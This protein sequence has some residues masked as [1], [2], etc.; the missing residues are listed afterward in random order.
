MI[1]EEAPTRRA[2]GCSLPIV[3]ALLL[4]GFGLLKLFEAVNDESYPGAGRI[5]AGVA[6]IAPSVLRLANRAPVQKLP[7]L[8]GLALILAGS[9]ELASGVDIPW[10]AVLMIAAGVV[11][12]LV[13]LDRRSDG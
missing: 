1:E 12:L 11:F 5:I 2:P 6:L 8:L 7:S 3:I 10:L 9:I 4:I 13:T